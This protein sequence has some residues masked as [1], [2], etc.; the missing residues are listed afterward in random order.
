[1]DTPQRTNTLTLA[2]ALRFLR[3]MRLAVVCM[4]ALAALGVEVLARAQRADFSPSILYIFYAIAAFDA[5]MSVVLRRQ[6][7]GPA[8]EILRQNPQDSAALMGWLKGQIIQ[9]PMALTLGLLG[10]MARFLGAPAI[11]VAPLYL[12]ALVI[13]FRAG[14]GEMS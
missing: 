14:R 9:M 2:D 7:A 5:V 8:G 11:S 13:L 10:V 4:M 3:Y 12:V 1:M 6:L